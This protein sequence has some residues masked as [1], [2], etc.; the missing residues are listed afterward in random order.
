MVDSERLCKVFAASVMQYF[1]TMCYT[2]YTNI[3]IFSDTLGTL[4]RNIGEAHFKGVAHESVVLGLVSS[5]Y[6][7]FVFKFTFER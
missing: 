3:F 5:K 7:Y 6:R 2:C 4:A 1:N